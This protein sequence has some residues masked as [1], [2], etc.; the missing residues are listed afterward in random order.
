MA[1]GVECARSTVYNWFYKTDLQPEDGQ[2]PDHVAVDEPVIRL[3]DEQ[4]WLY[5]TVDPETNELLHTKLE[6]TT[7]NIIDYAFFAELHEK[8]DVDD[9]PR[10]RRF[11]VCKRDAMRLVNAVLL[12]D[13]SHSMKNA[14][15]RHGLDFR[16]A[17]HG[18][19][20]AVRHVS[21]DIK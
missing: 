4:Y 17:K 5:A 11:L 6:S 14:S 13:G 20:D 12:V 18:N 21:R 16:Y 10:N 7:N 3:S 2:S 19:R 15:S 9:A 1:F 8:H